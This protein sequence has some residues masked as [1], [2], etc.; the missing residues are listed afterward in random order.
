M[1]TLIR[2][3]VAAWLLACTLLLSLSGCVFEKEYKSLP[4]VYPS[5]N[6]TDTSSPDSGSITVQ[7]SWLDYK[8]I[9]HAMGCVRGR[10]ATNSKDAFL[11]GYQM[12][13]RVFEVDLQLTSDGALVARHDWEQISYYNLEQD[14]AGVMDLETFLSTPI[15]FYYTPLDV[16]GLVALMQEYPDVY[17]VTDSKDSDE[18]TVRSQT[19]K[20]AQA[21]AN[22]GDASLWDRIIVQI[23]SEEM[24][25]W[26]RD[27]APVT[28]WIFTLYQIL[29]PDYDAIG[30]FCQKN[31]IP[32]ITVEANRLS[33][34]T[35][36]TVH[37]YGCKLYVHTV[38]RLIAMR[39]MSWAADG[40]YSDYVTPEQW[41]GVAAGTSIP[42]L[43]PPAEQP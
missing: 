37:S 23:Y 8:V 10:V 32:V 4:P 3:P 6:T 17:F 20:I 11:E 31:G 18:A 21:I 22:T 1:H 38:N 24:Y 2:G 41:A 35:A 36:D 42:Y 13:Q 26:I 25:G 12:G 7:T 14:G 40:F 34:S 28:N 9:A 15:C 29:A 27:E 16:N 5:A 19:Q 30:A 43:S 33:K 39:A